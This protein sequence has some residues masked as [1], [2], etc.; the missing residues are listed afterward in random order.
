M[1]DL[2][3]IQ[4]LHRPTS[5]KFGKL[6]YL[7]TCSCSLPRKEKQDFIIPFDMEIK[8]GTLKKF[9]LTEFAEIIIL[10]LVAHYW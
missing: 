9:H 1:M 4:L 8:T 3:R 10:I 7:R 6:T 5:T 2:A